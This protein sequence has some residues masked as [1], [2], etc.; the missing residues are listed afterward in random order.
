MKEV[1]FLPSKH[2]ESIYIKFRKCK[3]IYNDRKQSSVCL[4]MR[5]RI[6]GKKGLQW[7]MRTL[8]EVMNAFIA[9]IVGI[10][11]QAYTQV[12]IY[13]IFSFKNVRPLHVTFI[14]ITLKK[15]KRW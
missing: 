12:K 11:S 1:I 5:K 4:G 2:T 13:Q 9:L 7:D 14:S 10:A 8:L 15:K 6:A 3:L